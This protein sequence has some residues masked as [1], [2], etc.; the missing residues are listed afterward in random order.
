M[1]E[2]SVLLT[3]RNWGLD[4][5][6]L[7]LRS[8][9]KSTDVSSQIIVLDYGSDNSNELMRVCAEFGAEYYRVAATEWSRS[10]AM[11]A[12]A[13]KARSAFLIFADADLI[14]SPTVLAATVRELQAASHEVLMFSFRDLPSHIS[15]E[16]LVEDVDFER[17]DKEAIWRPRWGMGVQAYRASTFAE[18][19]GF[20]ERMKIYGG[21]DND[22]AKRA[23]FEGNH[24]RWVDDAEFG[25]YHVW[26]PSSREIADAD[27]EHKAVV[28]EN[29]SIA[30]NDPTRVRNLSN[31]QFGAPLVSVVITTHNRADYIVDSIRSALNQTVENLEVLVLDDGSTDNTEAVVR[32]I[33]DE[34]VRYF[35]FKKSGIP[36]LRNKALELVKG[37]YTAIHDDDDIMLPW[38]LEA[39][40]GS[41]RAGDGGAYGA[42]FNFDNVT[43]SMEL[44][45]GRESSRDTILNGGKVFLHATLLI[46]SS[47]LAAV[48]YDEKYT[49]GSDYNLAV[50]LAKAGIK[51]RHCREVVLLRRLHDRQVTV[52]DQAVQHSASYHTNFAQR[53]AWGA[54]TSAKSREISKAN[55]LIALPSEV[56]NIERSA[57]FLPD[58]LV[59]R[60]GLLPSVAK[61]DEDSSDCGYG[62][63]SFVGNLSSEEA[64]E[65]VASGVRVGVFQK[66][67]SDNFSPMVETLRL[68]ADQKRSDRVIGVG[69]P[70]SFKRMRVASLEGLP[71]ILGHGEALGVQLQEEDDLYE[72]IARI[73]KETSSEV[74]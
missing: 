71:T 47:L 38:S 59:Y 70:E 4:R 26:H 51:L 11:N 48:R 15:P 27:P 41:L 58:H 65:L 35:K 66:L 19:R 55:P 13:A 42:A 33:S 46:E 61:S 49:S 17:L 45:R 54:N 24:L 14:F 62:D 12:A 23:R 43:G 53:I 25:L 20:D 3:V 31:R 2:I 37:R 63:F 69:D 40:L 6:W 50:R 21:E 5:V 7:C 52:T 68:I 28:A 74:R 72:A 39:R 73:L 18:V 34:R 64:A 32:S 9:A 16:D 22:I 36:V 30:K 60:Y 57:A 8:L 29:A 67:G 1:A 44:L 10:L 56:A